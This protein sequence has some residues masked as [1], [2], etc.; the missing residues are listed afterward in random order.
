[1]NS[2]LET[3]FR[4]VS[5][6]MLG[7]Y[8]TLIATFELAKSLISRGVPGDFVEAGVYAGAEI[9]VMAKAIMVSGATGRRVHLFDS[10]Q[11]IPQPGP[12]DIEFLKAGTQAGGASHSMADTQRNMRAWGIP[13]ELL[14]YHPGWFA[15]TMPNNDLGPIALLRLDGDL[16]E[17]TMPCLRHL[18]HKVSVGGWV[19]VDDYPLQG[20]RKAMLEFFTEPPYFQ[21]F[22]KLIPQ[23]I[24]F[25]KVT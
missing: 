21:A 24:Y 13:G 8:E 7:E 4:R 14:V 18:Y 3:W 2:E 15:D 9:A 10:F 6:S 12:R 20:C 23:P 19:I 16:Y 25:Q 11:G 17:S 1:M 22:E 5:M